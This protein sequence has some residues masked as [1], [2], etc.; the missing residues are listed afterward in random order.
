MKLLKFFT[1]G[2]ARLVFDV[3]VEKT[4][5]A[6]E[7]PESSEDAFWVEINPCGLWAP[8][9]EKMRN[10]GSRYNSNGFES[11][12]LVSE[13]LKDCSPE[14]RAILAM[15][16]DH[17]RNLERI[18]EEDRNWLRKHRTAEATKQGP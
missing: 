17:S 11:Y 3:D 4:P 14:F 18:C 7:P 5:F 1:S 15:I 2:R 10:L 16:P 8:G 9:W 6:N 13:T 12:I